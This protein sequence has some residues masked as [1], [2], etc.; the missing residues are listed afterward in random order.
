MTVL[1]ST[2]LCLP[3]LIGLA[4][5]S[6][7][8]GGGATEPATDPTAGV[9]GG[10]HLDG[11]TCFDGISNGDEVG[12]DCGGSCEA[13]CE[14]QVITTLWSPFAE[15]SYENP[16][17]EQNPFDLAATATFTDGRTP[18]LFYDGDST[19]RLRF[20]CSEVGTYLFTTESADPDLDGKSGSVV[21]QDNPGALGSLVPGGRDGKKFYD[22]G[23]KRAVVPNWIM[24][25]TLFEWE[26]FDD[27][28]KHAWM[29]N[30]LDAAGWQ[31][32]HSPGI[33]NRWYDWECDGTAT[34]CQGDNPD[35][36]AF[37][38]YERFLE[39][40]YERGLYVHIW[41]WWD[42]Q[43]DLHDMHYAYPEP[44]RRLRH[45]LAD[46]L[47]VYPNLIVGHGFDNHEYVD[48]DPAY[49][50]TWAQDFVDRFAW[51]HFVEIRGEGSV[52]HVD[53]CPSCNMKSWDTAAD[54]IDFSYSLLA[55]SYD[56]AGKMPV[57]ETDRYRY[58]QNDGAYRE[59]D[60]DSLEEQRRWMWWLTM[61]GGVG[62]IWGNLEQQDTTHQPVEGIYSS[63]DGYPS[64]EWDQ[65]IRGW[66]DF[67]YATEA[68]PTH[69][70]RADMERCNDLTDGHGLCRRAS[71]YVFFKSDTD[72]IAFDLSALSG[73]VSMVAFDTNA[74]VF[75]P[76]P[77]ATAA[78]AEFR[79]P[80]ES[81]WAVAV[82]RFDPT[83]VSLGV[84]GDDSCDLSFE[85]PSD[86]PADCQ[87]QVLIDDPLQGSTVA[88]QVG[89]VLTAEG[90]R[91]GV[92][93]GGEN[94]LLYEVGAQVTRGYVELQVKGFD[95][96]EFPTTTSSDPSY[97]SAFV[98][99]YDGRGITEPASYH[100]EAKWNYFLWTV[101]Y[102]SPKY[103][104][105]A[106]DKFKS[107]V[108]CAAPTAERLSSSRAVFGDENGD[109]SYDFL[110]RDWTTEPNGI[111]WDWDS[112]RWYTIKVA[113]ADRELRV[114]CDGTEV[115][116][117]ELEDGQPYAEGD[118]PIV[119]PYDYAPVDLRIWLGSG[120]RRYSNKMPNI[121][122]RNFKVV[123][124]GP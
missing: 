82:G 78:T 15:W 90:Y 104:S 54:P 86:C 6:D 2:L 28:W 103:Q 39:Q 69:R 122:Y 36:R 105:S 101:H 44:R 76:L 68:D 72:R 64:A 117:N 20:M 27:D 89:G 108:N 56:D 111:H 79:A 95:M 46:R 55:K 9:G 77:D 121:V 80:H 88:T 70:F 98:T 31:G 16:S 92:D 11:G 50:D 107:I 41:L 60:V 43:R 91:P 18:H 87:A 102:R 34:N 19:W 120:Q 106:G 65:V 35:P 24:A 48:D 45:Y 83:D 23:R 119:A 38:A 123:D 112:T 26:A 33:A 53:L 52:A 84:C 1:R 61:V 40:F 71:H 4:C 17:Y 118:F 116:F 42:K 66:H 114:F 12:I 5:S 21:C 99:L 29:A 85:T 94:H 14:D 81:D 110:D 75:Y 115:W 62:A 22:L 58:R 8:T 57:M 25:P 49:P 100:P 113:W 73:S 96:D 63:V 3:I 10:E 37:A 59:K 124:E 30:N 74:G 7:P 67:W 109:G 97:E 47:G 51:P 93:N 13:R 32:V